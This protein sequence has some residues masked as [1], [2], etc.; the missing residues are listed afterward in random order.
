MILLKAKDVVKCKALKKI[1]RKSQNITY[2][3][4]VFQII[5]LFKCFFYTLFIC[6]INILSWMTSLKQ[7]KV[8][9]FTWL[10][11]YVEWLLEELNSLFY[12]REMKVNNVTE[13]FGSHLVEGIKKQ[14]QT[15]NH[16]KIIIIPYLVK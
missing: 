7:N 14:I 8:N 6:N 16:T 15:L 12:L 10:F 13:L 11:G 1:R 4:G 3:N 2:I 5:L 9:N